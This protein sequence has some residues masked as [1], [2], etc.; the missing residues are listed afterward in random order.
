MVPIQPANLFALLAKENKPIKPIKGNKRIKNRY[1]DI[2]GYKPFRQISG[3]S[4]V[5]TN[6]K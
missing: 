6:K 3:K 1:E 2:R 4:G 5:F